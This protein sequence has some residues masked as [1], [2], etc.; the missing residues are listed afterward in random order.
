MTP[1]S[2]PRG[3]MS[4]LAARLSRWFVSIHALF[5][6]AAF[7]VFYFSIDVILDSQIDDDLEEDIEEFSSVLTERGIDGLVAELQREAQSNA[8][9]EVF[10]RLQTRDGKALF[11]SDLSAWRP[12]VLKPLPEVHDEPW[13]GT[14]PKAVYG[15]AGR[16]IIAPIGE[17]LQ[18]RIGDSLE[19]KEAFMALLMRIFVSAFFVGIALAALAS[20]I[21]AQRGLHGVGEITRAAMDV[22]GGTLD[23]RVEVPR[24]SGREIAQLAEAF[25]TMVGRI[26][27]LVTGMREMTDNIAHDLR[28]PLARIQAAAE[29]ALS[30]DLSVEAHRAA[31]ADTMEECERLLHIINTTLDV[32]E[33]EAGAARQKRE[34]VDLS[35]LAEDVCELFSPLAEDHDI[36]LTTNIDTGC[37]VAGDPAYLQRML[38]NL[39]DNALKYTPPGGEVAVVVKGDAQQVSLTVTDTGIGIPQAEQARVFDRFYRSDQ[40]RSKEGCGLG[41][42]LV[43]AVVAAHDGELDLVSEPGQG[44][45]FSLRFP[46]LTRQ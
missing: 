8:P 23:R 7:L 46:R 36:G 3:P 34:A 11:S 35:R 16:V 22:A 17:G 13:L 31:A 10:F 25:N 26:R 15:H 19:D 30:H 14:I 4:G 18:L 6:A 37:R 5:T 32:T 27:A 39:I 43:R 28:S 38:A 2:S 9:D 44:S 12:T 20:W 24:A 21:V 45:R 1:M 33:V 42:S 41:L 40:S 29:T